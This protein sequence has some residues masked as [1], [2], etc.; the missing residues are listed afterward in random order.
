MKESSAIARFFF[1]FA[2]IALII[3]GMIVARTILVTLVWSLLLALIILPM[4]KWLEKHLKYKVLAISIGILVLIVVIGSVL[5][6]LLSQSFALINDLPRLTEKLGTAITEVRQFADQQLGIP[7]QEQPSELM[8]RLSNIFQESIGTLSNTFLDALGTI[9]MISLV[10][11]FIFL[12]LFYQQRMHEFIE[13]LYTGKD[14]ASVLKMF[15]DATAVVEKYLRGMIID[16]FIVAILAAIVFYALGIKYG[17]FFAVLVA[18]LNLIPFIG[19]FIAST[20]SI[21]F[22][23]ITKDSLWYPILVMLLLWGIQLLE[24]NIIKPYIVGREIDLNPFAVILAVFVGGM[25]WGVSGMVLFIPMLGAAKVV[26]D[27]TQEL[28]P[29]SYLLGDE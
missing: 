7:Y 23:F 19:V 29:Y 13:R 10:P 9:G 24:N 3:W 17:I 11:L 4:T 22:A 18:V 27:R 1:I 2:S 28:K 12:I 26:F 5:Y 25:I 14:S 21:L 20:V 6:L 15:D 8:V 16:T